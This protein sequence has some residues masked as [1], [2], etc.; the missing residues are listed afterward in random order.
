MKEG[1]WK[2]VAFARFTT[3]GT[4]VWTVIGEF[5]TIEKAQKYRDKAEAEGL[6]YPKVVKLG[7]EVT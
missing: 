3:E 2:V 6:L 4:K 5:D 1:E 7:V